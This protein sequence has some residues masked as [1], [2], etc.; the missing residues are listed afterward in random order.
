MN[1]P[2]KRIPT[3]Y[4]DEPSDKDRSNLNQFIKIFQ[5]KNTVLLLESSQFQRIVINNY[6][7]IFIQKVIQIVVIDELHL[8]IHYGRSFRDEFREVKCPIFA[9]LDSCQLWLLLTATCFPLT[10]ML[11]KHS[12]DAK[13]VKIFESCVE[14]ILLLLFA[15]LHKR[16]RKEV[17]IILQAMTN[18]MFI[19]LQRF[20]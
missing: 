8:C 20:W 3:I 18:F 1:I 17:E 5:T 16:W 13:I 10:F 19:W 6:F 9:P 14:L 2:D 11:L 7:I 4:L 15:T 12:S